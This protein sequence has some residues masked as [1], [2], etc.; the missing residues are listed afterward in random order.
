MSAFFQ[1]ETASDAW[2]NAAG[3]VCNSG[4]CVGLHVEIARPLDYDE[5]VVQ[6]VDNVLRQHGKIPCKDVAYTIFPQGLWQKLGRGDSERLF[7]LYNKPR[8]FY[9]RLRQHRKMSGHNDWGTYFQRMS[10]SKFD[11][12]GE[13]QLKRAVDALRRSKKPRGAIHLHTGMPDDDDL[14][15]HTGLPADG[16]R[17]R[18]GPCLQIVTVHAERNSHGYSLSACALYRNH[19]FFEKAL[20]NYVGLGQLL[21]FL[22]ESSEMTVGKLHVI[23]G[24]AYCSPVGP[25]KEVLHAFSS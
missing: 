22:A 8:G 24:H 25:I 4:D 16:M 3:F 1:V 14:H 23:S 7:N 12:R 5:A 18:G 11:G 6:A 13:G 17:V 21:G 19:D 9:E 2:R 10:S 15:L 20:G